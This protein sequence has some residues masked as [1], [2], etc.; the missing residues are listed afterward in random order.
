MEKYD[1]NNLSVFKETLK[2][3]DKLELDR[4]LIDPDGI[5]CHFTKQVD[6][7]FNGYL[8]LGIYFVNNNNN[9][10][11][12]IVYQVV[13]GE[14][15]RKEL[16]TNTQSADTEI[17]TEIYNVCISKINNS[18]AIAKNAILLEKN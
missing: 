18:G 16:I 13:I 14:K 15:D 3:D 9:L 11:M 8:Y 12:K 1:L 4:V 2:N 6:L 17:N 10:F 5:N 7:V